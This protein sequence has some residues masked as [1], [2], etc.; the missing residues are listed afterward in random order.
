MNRRRGGGEP[1]HKRVG[2][3][4]PANVLIVLVASL[5]LNFVLIA[6]HVFGHHASSIAVGPDGS[7]RGLPERSLDNRSAA[8]GGG[9]DGG[10]S[11]ASS[12][13]GGSPPRLPKAADDQRA[14]VNGDGGGTTGNYDP[15]KCIR[16]VKGHCDDEEGGAWRYRNGENDECT[17][18]EVSP[19][20]NNAPKDWKAM[21]KLPRVFPDVKSVMDYGGGPGTYLTALRNAGAS[22]LVT[23]EPHPL[24]DC[25]FANITQDTTDWVNAPLSDLPSEGTFDLAMTIEVLEH[26]PS[27]HHEHVILA[28]ARA[29]KSWLLFSAARPGQGGEGHVGPSMK[30]RETWIED[31]VRWT[32]GRLVV[33]EEKT[34]LF[35]EGLSSI[36]LDNSVIFRKV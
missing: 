9:G 25:L 18:V 34:A 15:R 11:S 33:D 26:I 7:L 27:V 35:H 4:T 32:D 23:V 19:E 1:H 5:S 24:G 17:Y 36:L 3:I 29:T 28:L 21:D 30:T 8:A 2:R 12:S 16:M 22:R 10:E 20:S 31:I 13:G 6:L 14:A